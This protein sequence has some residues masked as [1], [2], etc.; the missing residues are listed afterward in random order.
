MEDSIMEHMNQRMGHAPYET[1][2]KGEGRLTDTL[3]Q[4]KLRRGRGP[5]FGWKL[6][7]GSKPKRDFYWGLR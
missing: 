2:L 1:N 5:L 7:P 4:E 6:K 3:L